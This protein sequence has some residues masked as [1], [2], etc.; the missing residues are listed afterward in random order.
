M[1]TYLL[2]M[3]STD[4]ANEA[5]ADVDFEELMNAMGQLNDELIRAGVLPAAEGLDT[6]GSS[7]VV[8]DSLA[9]RRS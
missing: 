1:S 5:L 6:E 2:I 7:G 3:R 9:T 4:E 8:V